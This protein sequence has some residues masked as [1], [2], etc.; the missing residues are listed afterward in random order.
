ML[1]NEPSPETTS[2]PEL[3]ASAPMVRLLA[4][5]LAPFSTDMTPVPSSATVAAPLTVNSDPAPD[6]S[7]CASADASVA[8]SSVAALTT[9]PLSIHNAPEP[10]APTS[11]SPLTVR[12]EPVPIKST[13]EPSAVAELAMT[14][15]APAVTVPPAW[16]M[17]APT[18]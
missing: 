4:V 15:P 5:K 12:P 18:P 1:N 14:T 2:A 13:S 3:S 7:I 16:I 6:R 9:A 11:S 10:P 17:R 8:A